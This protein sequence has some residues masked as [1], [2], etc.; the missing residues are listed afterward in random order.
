MGLVVVMPY[1]NGRSG[2]NLTAALIAIVCTGSLALAA[3]GVVWVM[4]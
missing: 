3:L 4:F 1:D 2:P